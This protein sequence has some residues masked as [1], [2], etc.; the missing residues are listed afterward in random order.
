MQYEH[1]EYMLLQLG[2]VIDGFK[3]KNCEAV[4]PLAAATDSQVPEV[5]R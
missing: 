1:P 5:T 2:R 4:S 3:S